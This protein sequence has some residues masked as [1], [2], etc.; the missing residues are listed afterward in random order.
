MW[1][2]CVLRRALDQIAF[3]HLDFKLLKY[4]PKTV[5]GPLPEM[6][7]LTPMSEATRAMLSPHAVA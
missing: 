1:A 5:T 6:W 3:A 2:P 7:R 4:D